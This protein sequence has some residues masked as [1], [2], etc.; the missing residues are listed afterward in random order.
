MSAPSSDQP[1]APDAGVEAGA[2]P[3]PARKPRDSQIGRYLLFG[4]VLVVVLVAGAGGWAAIASISGAV[5]AP[6]SIVVESHRKDVAHLQGGII[7][8]IRVRNG[9]YVQAGDV[10]VRLDGTLAKANLGIVT[11]QLDEYFLRRARLD[12]ELADETVLTLP[13]ALAARSGEASVDGIFKGQARLL[14][15]RLAALQ[16]KRNQLREQIGQLAQEI[17]GLEAQRDAK[18][19]EIA[20]IAEELKGVEQLK[21]KGLVPMNRVVALKRQAAQ[22]KGDHGRLISEIARAKGR[23]GETEIQVIQLDMDRKT[24]VVTEARDVK[25]KIAE[26]TERRV[27]AEDQL[28][29]IEIHAPIAGHVHQLAVHTVGG[30]V[31]AGETVLQIVPTKDTL[32]VEARLDPANIDQVQTGQ[33]ATVRFPSFNQRTTPELTGTVRHISADVA[34]DAR[35]EFEFYTIRVALNASEIA[36][37]GT[38]KLVP[39]MPTEVF[40]KTDQRTALSYLVK[41]LTDQIQRAFREE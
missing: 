7:G 31:Q 37:L 36:R 19:E 39:G 27:A 40:I 6:G 32:L 14:A 10:L 4:L 18:A 13:A 28:R 17:T 11:S 3:G 16:G 9:D 29:R 23:I 35:M 22:L 24:E 26:L 2:G 1:K 5:I 34:K 20:L 12:A 38:A 25:M 41:P 33:E 30:V 8:E 21:K 15:A